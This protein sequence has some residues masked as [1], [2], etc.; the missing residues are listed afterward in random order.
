M[1]QG[2]SL[3]SSFHGVG[4]CSRGDEACQLCAAR[5]QGHQHPQHGDV[6]QCCKGTGSPICKKNRITTS[7]TSS[8]VLKDSIFTLI[9]SPKALS[10]EQQSETENVSRAKFSCGNTAVSGV[11]GSRPPCVTTSARFCSPLD[12]SLLRA[13]QQNMILT[14]SPLTHLCDSPGLTKWVWVWVG[15]RPIDFIISKGC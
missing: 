5:T 8:E 13:M 14:H 4:G 2:P 11:Q 9:V 1:D 6:Q 7:K 10:K 12:S 15:L 3:R